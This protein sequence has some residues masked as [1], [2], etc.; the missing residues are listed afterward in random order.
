MYNIKSRPKWFFY[1]IRG[2]KAEKIRKKGKK[3]GTGGRS[4]NSFFALSILH[5]LC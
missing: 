1:E 5:A 4:P 2:K 3:K